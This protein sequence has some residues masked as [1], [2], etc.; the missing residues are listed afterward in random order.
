MTTSYVSDSDLSSLTGKSGAR[1][2][3]HSH[4]TIRF[5]AIACPRKGTKDRDGRN[6]AAKLPKYLA[7]SRLGRSEY[8]SGK[9]STVSPLSTAFIISR[10]PRNENLVCK[11]T[12]P[13][14]GTPFFE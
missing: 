6:S 8:P 11:V 14:P 10:K 1:V 2:C 9:T 13:Q 5:A 4:G 12:V 3:R 7:I